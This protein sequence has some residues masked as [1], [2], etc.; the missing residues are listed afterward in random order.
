MGT[1]A[2][3]GRGRGSGPRGG[4]SLRC[5]TTPAGCVR[6]RGRMG[7][8]ELGFSTRAIH[9]GKI[10]D[11]NKSVVAPLYQ[12]AT[13]RYDAVEEGAGLGAG[14]G[15]GYFYTRWGNP[16]TDRFEQEMALRE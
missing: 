12:T 4:N 8:S 9:G 1:W 6:R 10:P 2:P 11:A 5:R 16:T 3:V 7:A 15:P 13:F 14:T